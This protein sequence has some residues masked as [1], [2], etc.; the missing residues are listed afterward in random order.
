MIMITV[1]DQGE[2]FPSGPIDQI[3]DPLF[4]TK[5]GGKGM[6]LFLSKQIAIAH[7]GDLNAVPGVPQGAEFILQLPI[8]SSRLFVE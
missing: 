1:S 5:R 4:S 2:G 3:F 8:D 6:G 7:G